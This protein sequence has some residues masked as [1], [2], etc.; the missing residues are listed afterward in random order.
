MR[1]LFK[2]T[3]V[4][5]STEEIFDFFSKPENL[6]LLTPDSLRFR[7][8]S[9]LPLEM[10][11]GTII[12]YSIKLG[13]I[14]FKWRTEITAWEPPF[15]FVDTQLKGPYRVWIHEHTF[16]PK[17]SG[18]IVRDSVSYLAPGWIIEPVIHR[19][20]IKNKLE[21]IFDYREKKLKSIFKDN[22]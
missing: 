12:D 16:I 7:I 4:P 1:N 10:K 2:E 20:L 19:L 14:P 17:D 8:L 5:F 3:F 6:N 22:D 11:Q 15:R 21:D 9:A 18:T 13:A